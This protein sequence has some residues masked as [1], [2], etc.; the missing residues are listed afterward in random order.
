[1]QGIPEIEEDEV[2]S[3]NFKELYSFDTFKE[4]YENLNEIKIRSKD[5]ENQIN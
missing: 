3:L 1:M 4:M 2:K 5:K